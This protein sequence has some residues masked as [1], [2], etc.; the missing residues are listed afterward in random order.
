MDNKLHDDTKS[1]GTITLI[2]DRVNG[3]RERHTIKNIFT[4]K[5]LN[6]L[7]ALEAGEA[8]AK[9][10]HMAL[11]TGTTA[12]AAGD[13]ALQAEIAGSRVAVTIAG[14]GNTR[15]YTAVFADG[16]GNGAVTEAG[17]LTAASAGELRNR[18]VFGVKTKQAGETFTMIWTL[19]HNRA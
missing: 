10:S 4:D 17:L 2:I 11:G 6:A 5:G 16:V 7:S 18:S 9:I 1:Q 15:T 13:T 19:T 3:A 14:S 12:A 8:V